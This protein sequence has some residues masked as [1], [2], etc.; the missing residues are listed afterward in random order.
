VQPPE[1]EYSQMWEVYPPGLY[2]LLTRLWRDYGAPNGGAVNKIIV[3]E[4]GICVPDTL[5]SDG[6]VHDQKRIRYLRDHLVQV[7]RVMDAGVPVDGYFVWSLM[8][9]FEWQLGYSMRFGLVFVDFTTLKRTLKDSGLW[10]RQVIAQHGF[11]LQ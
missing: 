2:D 1:S 6:C 11:D 4:N 5:E 8:D 7:R 3:T 10:F 9:N